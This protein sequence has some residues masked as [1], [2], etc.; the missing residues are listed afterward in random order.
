MP[1]CPET[2]EASFIQRAGL[3]LTDDLEL[4]AEAGSLSV[5]CRRG[6]S[7]TTF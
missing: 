4:V 2:F 3:V 5:F 1:P 6:Q 7:W